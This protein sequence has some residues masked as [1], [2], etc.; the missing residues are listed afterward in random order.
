M[1]RGTQCCV[2]KIPG[3][4]AAER[5]ARRR[6]AS[7]PTAPP[8]VDLSTFLSYRCLGTTAYCG[9]VPKRHLAMSAGPEC[10]VTFPIENGMFG[11]D[12]LAKRLNVL[13]SEGSGRVRLLLHAAGACANSMIGRA[14]R[15]DEWS[16]Q[17]A[18]PI[19][20]KALRPMRAERPRPMT[21]VGARRRVGDAGC[22]RGHAWC[23]RACDQRGRTRLVPNLAQSID[24]EDCDRDDSDMT[25]QE[26][27]RRLAES[28]QHVW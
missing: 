10:T 22:Q 11:V 27:Q 19:R 21:I 6:S 2:V 3:S 7:S 4:N 24:Q 23:G 5:A 20:K 15:S 8:T 26:D 1:T 16:R 25:E 17:A 12:S 13:M 28:A 18:V 14:Q 9:A